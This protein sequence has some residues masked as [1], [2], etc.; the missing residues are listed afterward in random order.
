MDAENAPRYLRDL[1]RGLF[2][3]RGEPHLLGS[4]VTR[5]NPATLGRESVGT[6]IYRVR[7]G[8]LRPSF[9]ACGGSPLVAVESDDAGLAALTPEALVLGDTPVGGE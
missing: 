3:L 5:E 2:Y 9:E 4:A 1:V 7:D 6:V 8:V